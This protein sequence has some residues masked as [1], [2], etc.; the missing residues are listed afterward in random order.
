MSAKLTK[1]VAKGRQFRFTFAAEA[2]SERIMRVI[3][4]TNKEEDLINAVGAA[5]NV[6]LR[7]LKFDLKVGFPTETFTDVD[8]LRHRG[9]TC[10]H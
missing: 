9:G 1:Q 5:V 2:G 7:H 8:A 3:N 6:V 4:K 10:S